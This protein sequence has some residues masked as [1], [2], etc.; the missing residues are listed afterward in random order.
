MNYY[1]PNGYIDMKKI[2]EQPYPFIFLIHGRGTGKTYGACKYVLDSKQKFVY[3]RRT[4]TEA[5][6]CSSAEFS[7]FKALMAD[8]PEL[9]II[10]DK[11]PNVKN[12]SGFYHGEMDE[13]TSTYKPAGAAIGYSTALTSIA[14]IRGFSME[15]CTIVIYDEFIPEPSARARR[16][17][18]TALLNGYETISRNR[19]LK[20]KPP[21]KLVCLSNANKIA[22][23][24]FATLGIMTKINQ[25]VMNDKEV[26]IIPDR[27]IAVYKLRDSPISE[28]KQSTSLYKATAGTDFSRMAID[29]A[30][31]SSNWLYVRREPIAEYKPL[32]T[33]ED[34][35]IYRHKSERGKYYV[36]RHE[37]GN[38][39]R[40]IN[41]PM[42]VKQFRRAYALFFE[43]WLRGN[44][45]F[46]DYYC[47]Y[48]LTAICK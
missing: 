17:E 39:P 4:Q 34:V 27:G 31:D 48:L 3:L 24:I 23:P 19:E 32:V 6:L 30:F 1:L 29:N 8:D 2:I 47:K 38:P 20:G 21:L 45:S 7:P 9:H 5:D 33:F 12:V 14:Q 11:I 42:S 40:Y 16:H 41:E 46:E 44:V 43:A 26:C 13:K 37:S 10:S 35:T 25:M 36:S 28:R 22:A 15:D 18:D